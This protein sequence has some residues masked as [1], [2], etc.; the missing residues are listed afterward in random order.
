MVGFSSCTKEEIT[1]DVQFLESDFFGNCFQISRDHEEVVIRTQE[2]YETLFYT[3]KW[4]V[5][6]CGNYTFPTIDFK[7]YTLIGV[8]TMGTGCTT[9]Y[10]RKVE[11]KGNQEVTYNVLVIS[12][13]VCLPLRMDMNWA[14]I[15]K[16][17][18]RTDVTFY[19]EAI[20]TY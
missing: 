12:S 10:E 18:K 19:V 15:P 3:Q 7:K 1:E 14:L 2:E 6:S 11:Q 13:G 4:D 17:K 8:Y 20:A 9:T 5:G 16:I